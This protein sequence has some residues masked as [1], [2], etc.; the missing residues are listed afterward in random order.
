MVRAW[1]KHVPSYLADCGNF[2]VDWRQCAN[3]SPCLGLILAP[4]AD[5]LNLLAVLVKPIVPAFDGLFALANRL[6]LEDVIVHYGTPTSA[7]SLGKAR[8]GF[9][10]II[11]RVKAC[12]EIFQP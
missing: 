4:F 7:A 10:G 6:F 1:K 11:C 9:G 8:L 2:P 3:K 5:L 12:K